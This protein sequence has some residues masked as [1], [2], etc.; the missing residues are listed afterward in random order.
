M[1]QFG[2]QAKLVE[3]TTWE[4]IVMEMKNKM[5]KK[6]DKD[7]INAAEWNTYCVKHQEKLSKK[8]S[9]ENGVASDAGV[10]RFVSAVNSATASVSDDI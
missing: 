6:S 9:Q 2:N 7:E 5:K 10:K 3:Q 8:T 1:R 4:E